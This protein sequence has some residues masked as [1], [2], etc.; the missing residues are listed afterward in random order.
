MGWIAACPWSAVSC[1]PLTYMPCASLVTRL[2]RTAAES[3]ARRRSRSATSR[4]ARAPRPVDLCAPVGRCS[5]RQ[6]HGLGALTAA[7]CLALYLRAAS[8][9][10][11]ARAARLSACISGVHRLR[12]SPWACVACVLHSGCVIGAGLCSE[13]VVSPLMCF[14]LSDVNGT[15]VGAVGHSVYKCSVP[16]EPS[17]E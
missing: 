4:L 14:L 2:R 17:P 3:R 9:Q 12:P 16:S 11:A 8:A 15:R 13:P 5:M 10:A 7:A 6:R 1:T